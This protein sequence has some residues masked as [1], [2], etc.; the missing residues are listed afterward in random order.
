MRGS[1]ASRFSAATLLV[2]CSAFAAF[3]DGHGGHGDGSEVKFT[4]PVESL[5]G[6]AGLIGDWHIAGRTVHVSSTT[7]IETE[8]GP[9][10]VGSTVKV[11][12]RARTDATIDATKIEAEEQ[13]EI[14]P[15]AEF[16]GTIQQLPATAGFVGD[17]LV[18]GKTIHV[19]ASTRIETEDGPVVV[20]AL[21]EV[22]GTIRADGSIDAV[23]IEVESNPQGDDGRTE[24]LGTIQSLPS[25][26]L[27]GDWLVSG[28]TIHVTADTAIDQ[29]HGAPAVGV[30]VEVK[31]ALRPDGSIDA[32]KIE[33]KS[34][35]SGEGGGDDHSGGSGGGSVE[36]QSA[37]FKGL[38]ED[39]P[40]STSLLGDWTISGRMVHVVSSTKLKSEHGP[41]TIGARVKV[42]GILMSDGSLVATKIQVR[43]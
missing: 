27:L 11:E 25:G 41:F 23:R 5:P 30:V 20:G 33:T 16:K 39:L 19:T 2:L 36:G 35:S 14:E 8:H 40:A 21:V 38:V 18:A 43:D 31:G 1:L 10:T 15:E 34:G 26:G 12:G 29:E 24:L 3:A 13:A 17:W 9:I 4:G 37:G 28:R 32:T 22:K 6:G 42:K 7:R